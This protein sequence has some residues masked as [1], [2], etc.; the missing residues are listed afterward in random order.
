MTT[1]S[2]KAKKAAK[3]PVPTK[4]KNGK[5]AKSHAMDPRLLATLGEQDHRKVVAPYV[6]LIDVIE[7]EHGDKVWV[8]DLRFTQPNQ[9]HI[10]MAAVHSLEHS[11][12]VL[13]RKYLPGRFIN[14]GCM[15]CQTGFYL[16][17]LNFGDYDQMLDLVAKCLNDILEQTEVPLANEIAC[18]W[19]ANHSLEGA[20][21]IAR[22][23]LEKRHKWTEVFS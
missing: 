21:E 23:V 7:G 19:A 5:A 4:K 12:A 18:G 1:T 3:K 20:Q 6:K 22:A 2:V 16:P 13:M 11:I 9:V 8:W 15:G 14:F 10:P 17:V